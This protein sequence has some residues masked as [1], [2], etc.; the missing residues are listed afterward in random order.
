MINTAKPNN[1]TM[2]NTARVNI[3]EVW[4][5]DSNTWANESRTWNA[6]AS[7]IINSSRVS[8]SMTNVAKPI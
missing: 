3:G 2:A 4:N 6:T 7:K 5:T 1:S 8:S